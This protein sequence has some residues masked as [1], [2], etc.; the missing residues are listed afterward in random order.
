MMNAMRKQ[1]QQL[2]Q[3]QRPQQQ[4]PQQQRP[5]QQRPQ[6]QQQE[7]NLLQQTPSSYRPAVLDALRRFGI[8]P[9]GKT[10]PERLRELLNEL[11]VFE[12][13]D[14]KLR[15]KEKERV[16]GPQS[17]AEYRHQ[18]LRIKARYSLLTVPPHHWL[19]IPRSASAPP[20]PPPP[21]S[22]GARR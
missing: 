2:P 7:P 4:R 5:Q 20:P 17:M 21:R 3:Q 16:L 15:H 13:R 6:Q 9:R 10:E 8:V 11:Y 22:V 14:L 12:I 18:L 19:D 1:P